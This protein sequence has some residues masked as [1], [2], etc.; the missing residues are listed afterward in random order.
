MLENQPDIYLEVRDAFDAYGTP[1]P[2]GCDELYLRVNGAINDPVRL[3]ELLDI[4]SAVIL[5]LATL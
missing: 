5:K 2:R 1:L 3:R 4:Y